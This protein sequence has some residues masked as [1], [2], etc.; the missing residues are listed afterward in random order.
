MA[1]TR[2]PRKPTYPHLTVMGPRGLHGLF[3]WTFFDPAN[4]VSVALILTSAVLVVVS[5]RTRGAPDWHMAIGLYLCL[6]AF[7]RGY[8]FKYY[9]GRMYS[10]VAVLLVLVS[11]LA[12]SALLWHDRA[13]PYE[14]FRAGKLTELPE[15]PAFHVAALLHVVTAATLVIHFA[16]PRRWLVRAT[17]DIADR[18]GPDYAFNAPADA[19]DRHDGDAN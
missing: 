4:L 14:L 1:K 9:H 19:P 8:M 5:M 12:A 6:L 2:R 11:G 17:D 10:R 13:A 18:A 7:L 16:L 3:G 15:A